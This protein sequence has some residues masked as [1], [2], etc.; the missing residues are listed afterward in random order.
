M[1]LK[2]TTKEWLSVAIMMVSSAVIIFNNIGQSVQ[3]I[4][5][6]LSKISMYWIAGISLGIG[7]IW[8]MYLE[9]VIK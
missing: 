7:A 5:I 4:Q 6:P 2:K 1:T 3:L 9:K 8:T